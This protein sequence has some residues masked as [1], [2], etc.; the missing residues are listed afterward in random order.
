MISHY[1]KVQFIF[2]F[3]MIISISPLIFSQGTVKGNVSDTKGNAIVGANVFLLNSTLGAASDFDGN[4]VIEKVPAKDYSLIIS[5]VGYKK[6]VFN[7]SVTSGK[8]VE[9]N[10][11]L[12]QDVLQM[13]SVVITGTAGG[14]GIQ[15][16][17]ASFA[18][19]T[20]SPRQLEQFHH[21]VP[22]P[23]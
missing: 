5:A 23:H 2:L 14:S 16:K 15:K 21:R 3:L 6:K 17:D 12:Q 13:E 20:I 11:T 8:T 19:T 1:K 4:Y 10:A 22:Q 9:Q 7:V 18:I